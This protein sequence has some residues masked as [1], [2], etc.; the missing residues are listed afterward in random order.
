MPNERN[1]LLG[2]GERLTEPVEIIGGGRLKEPPYSF[3]EAQSRIV[4]MLTGTFFSPDGISLIG[5][6]RVSFG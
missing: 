2:Y 1:Y 4:P 6:D 5:S 3:E